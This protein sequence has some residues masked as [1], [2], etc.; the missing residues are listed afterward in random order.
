LP[1]SRAPRPSRSE[2]TSPRGLLVVVAAS[3]TL[4]AGDGN[5]QPARRTGPPALATAAGISAA[6]HFARTRS[7]TVSFA[8]ATEDGRIRGHNLTVP[9]RAASVVKAMLLVA[10]LRRAADRALSVQEAGLLNPMITASDN[11]AAH[12]VYETIG[13]SGL[14][15]VGRA[16]RMTDLGLVGAVF[17]TRITAADQV[18]FFLRIDRL[19]PLRHRAYARALLAGIIGPQRWGIAR[20]AQARH[21]RIFFKGGWRKGITHQVALLERDRGRVALAVLTTGEPS[22]AYGQATLAGI[23]ARA[24]AARRP[25]STAAGPA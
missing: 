2:T 5:E 19:V 9:H 21:F 24:L 1:L 10:V 16:A 13:D 3:L 22:L 17:E 15:A 18:R 8:V 20:V 23:A 11:E 4:A 7:G 14:Q 6:A 25:R 12:T